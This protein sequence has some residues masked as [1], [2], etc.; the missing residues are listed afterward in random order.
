MNMAGTIVTY[1][2]DKETGVISALDGK[3]YSFGGADWLSSGFT[4][5]VSLIVAFEP[6]GSC[7]LKIRVTGR[8]ILLK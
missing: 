7:A 2:A 5:E 6:A 4:P 8:A 1:E 3:T